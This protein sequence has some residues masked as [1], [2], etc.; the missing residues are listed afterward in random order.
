MCR[1]Y[2]LHMYLLHMYYICICLPYL[3]VRDNFPHYNLPT[4][5]L[6]TPQLVYR[7]P[8][9]K[10]SSISHSLLQKQQLLT[11]RTVANLLRLVTYAFCKGTSMT[12]QILMVFITK[13]C[14]I[15][16]NADIICVAKTRLKM[17]L[18]WNL[19]IMF[20]RQ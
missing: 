9:H 7:P 6:S 13:I 3:T 5:L 12:G 18:N 19:T 10:Q 11:C 15:H 8:S 2:V 4:R 1:T 16:F 14:I 17:I 20:N